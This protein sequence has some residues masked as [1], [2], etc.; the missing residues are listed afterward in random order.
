M[1]NVDNAAI[2]EGILESD[3]ISV[4]RPRRNID[5]VEWRFP[6][7]ESH[8]W[9]NPNGTVLD[10][11]T[12]VANNGRGHALRTSGKFPGKT[13]PTSLRQNGA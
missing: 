9:T 1:N 3:L 7:R 6:Q 4:D 11:V 10:A 5:L 13:I 8:A 12:T 2:T